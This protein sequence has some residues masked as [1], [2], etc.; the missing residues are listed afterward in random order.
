MLLP[1]LFV[2]KTHNKVWDQGII[3]LQ[4]RHQKPNPVAIPS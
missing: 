2:S 1:K 4:S 3:K